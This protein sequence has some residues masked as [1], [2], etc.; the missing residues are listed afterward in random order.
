MTGDMNEEREL[1][2]K[3]HAGE[4]AAAVVRADRR[5][6]RSLAGAVV[7]AAV[8][9]L[10]WNLLDVGALM[11]PLHPLLLAV[12]E[13]AVIALFAW[14]YLPARLTTAGK[15]W[16]ARE[17]RERRAALRLRAVPRSAWGTIAA[18][19]ASSL[20]L[21]QLVTMVWFHL[22]P[23]ANDYANPL[24]ELL[25]RPFGWL[26]V[27]LTLLVAAP[28]MEE[29]AFRGWVQRPLERR[30]GPVVA[31]AITSLLFALAH[32]LPLLI[33]YYIVAGVVLGAS[34]Y[35]TRSLWV[36]MIVHAA[37]NAWSNASDAMGL[38]NERAIEWTAN[39]LVFW[40]AVAGLAGWALVMVWLGMRLREASRRC[41][42]APVTRPL[43]S[44]EP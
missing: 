43:T 17:E 37:H 2:P 1:H 29:V 28:L 11:L 41:M 20:V 42:P 31:I 3:M 30:A 24:A 12:V 15:P 36:A 33:P 40:L 7:V 8:V 23:R 9:F 6:R 16:A 22:V 32:G 21:D 4:P 18:W 35:L 14:R 13:L 27:Y 10:F 34:V 26:P 38:T 5:K 25:D 39:P 19:V 44:V